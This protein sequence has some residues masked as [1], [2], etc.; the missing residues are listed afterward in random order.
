KQERLRL[1][2]LLLDPLNYQLTSSLAISCAVS[3]W[4]FGLRQDSAGY[5]FHG[6][7][8]TDSVPYPSTGMEGFKGKRA[9]DRYLLKLLYFSLQQLAVVM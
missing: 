6:S 8:T 4:A 7:L 1:E 2:S 5:F 9:S 3:S